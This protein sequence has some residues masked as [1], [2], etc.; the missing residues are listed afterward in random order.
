MFNVA[1]AFGSVG[2]GGDSNNIA[3]FCFF[4]SV[5]F[6]IG[7]IAIVVVIVVKNNIIPVVIHTFYVNRKQWEIG[8]FVAVKTGNKRLSELSW[9][10]QLLLFSYATS[11]LIARKLLSGFVIKWCHKTK[12]TLFNDNKNSV[13]QSDILVQSLP[14]QFFQGA[15]HFNIKISLPHSFACNTASHIQN[16]D[17]E[18][19][20]QF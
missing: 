12:I 4:I 8:M 9:R 19:W 15:F 20:L 2:I 1:A 16:I 13:L 18:T 17:P 10:R 14:A 6:F 11:P 7:F 3:F 5:F